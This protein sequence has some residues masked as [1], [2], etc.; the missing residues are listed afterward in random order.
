MAL[1]S[2]DFANA[3]GKENKPISNDDINNQAFLT[4]LFCIGNNFLLLKN[5]TARVIMNRWAVSFV[6]RGQPL[7]KNELY[8]SGPDGTRT[9]DLR[10]DRAAF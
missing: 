6:P 7:L 2:T 3:K 5:K 10:R 1:F 9:R 8:S 4:F